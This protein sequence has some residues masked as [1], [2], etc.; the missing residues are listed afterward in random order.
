VAVWEDGQRVVKPMRY[1]CRPAGL[2]SAVRYREAWHLQR[3]ARQ[4]WRLLEASV[5]LH[6]RC[7]RRWS[8]LR[9]RGMPGQLPYLHQQCL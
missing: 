6:T 4:P 2:P 9:A 3:Q 1:Q 7:D 8:L 5:R